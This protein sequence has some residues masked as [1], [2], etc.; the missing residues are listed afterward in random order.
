MDSIE[1]LKRKRG[2]ISVKISMGRK[3]GKDVSGL[4]AERD[5][6]NDMIKNYR[7]GGSAPQNGPTQPNSY[8]N[9]N[10][11]DYKDGYAAAIEAIKKALKG[12]GS[13]NQGKGA[14]ESDD[15]SDMQQP[16]V[17]GQNNQPGQGS[18][19]SGS[20]SG[21]SSGGN[22]GS[23]G[24][25]RGEGSCGTVHAEDCTQPS[26]GPGGYPGEM[27]DRAEGDKIAKSEGYENNGKSEAAQA[28]DFAETAVKEST[29]LKGDMPGNLKSVIENLYKTNTDWKQAL[30]KVVGH[31]L[32]PEDK[33]QAYANKNV[34][35]S[36]DR[37]A[38]TDKD[39][40]DNMD[41]MAVFIDSSGSMTDNQ[42]QICLNEVYSV[43]LKK[44]PIKLVIIQ[45]DTRIQQVLEYH[46]L[47]E[48][49]KDI[50]KQGVK[51]R[52]GTELK[53]CWDFL[54]DDP[55]YKRRPAELVMCFTDGYLTQYKRDPRH[56]GTLCW[57]I[58]DNTSFQVQNKEAKTQCIYINTADVK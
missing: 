20:G 24:G 4:E 17:S 22:G 11:K 27:V 31:A 16:P 45:C 46:S 25:S 29:K 44:K 39:K 12:E 51:G 49:K 5:K 56:M 9:T 23:G 48:F 47:S 57:V 6:I 36:Q 42:L 58:L 40:Y 32:S 54:A 52:G 50:I 2:T 26:S 33:R 10:S 30:R 55:K 15:N 1:D 37:I 14:D 8:T 34:L 3:A 35:I 19:G 21:K 43:A 41:Y 7:S 53:P 18:G 28:Q 38:R 13:G